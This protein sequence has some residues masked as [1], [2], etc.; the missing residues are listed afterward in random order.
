MC[1]YIAHTNL[2]SERFL[3]R[4]FCRPE[5]FL[6]VAIFAVASAVHCN[7]CPWWN[8]R[9]LA[10]F[11]DHLFEAHQ[12]SLPLL[13][14]LVN[15]GWGEIQYIKNTSSAMYALSHFFLDLFLLYL[16]F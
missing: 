12:Q 4:V 10:I 13:F 8:I 1:T 6:Q 9:A 11:Q 7:C 14:K 15:L 16:V 2:E 3:A 5:L